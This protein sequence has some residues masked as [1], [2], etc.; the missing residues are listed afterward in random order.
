LNKLRGAFT[1]PS[2]RR[3]RS[4]LQK[5][6]PDA[7]LCTH[8]LPL[9]VLDYLR[10]KGSLQTFTASIVTDF[11]AHALWMS[12]CVDLY[13]VAA[14]HTKARLIARGATAG[15]VA[16]TGIPIASR[17]RK[18]PTA[19]DARK[20]LGLRDDQPVLLV[21]GGGFGWGPIA[22]ILQGL[23][24]LKESFQ[25]VVVCGRNEELRAKLAV[26]D[27]QHPTHLLGFAANMHELLAAANLVITKPGGLTTSEALAVGRPILVINPIPGQEAANSDFL[28]EQGAGVKINRVE[29]LPFRVGKLLGSDKLKAMARISRSV[30]QPDAA[31][32]VCREV[33]ARLQK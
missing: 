13:C 21:L 32:N 7:V 18:P 14:E 16:V 30:G 33:I 4:H 28:L 23:D 27:R 2:T 11:E 3:I 10:V 24:T 26:Q 5:F 22:E 1:G 6:Q 17:F 8:Y 20:R 25:T 9:E 12:P 29:D 31:L 19:K 15:Q